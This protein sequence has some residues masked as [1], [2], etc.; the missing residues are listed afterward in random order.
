MSLFFGA[1][2]FISFLRGAI[3]TSLEP[4]GNNLRGLFYFWSSMTYVSS[5]SFRRGRL[6]SLIRIWSAIVGLLLAVLAFRWIAELAAWPI[7]EQWKS[8]GVWWPRVLDAPA[9]LVIA[10]GVLFCLY[11]HQRQQGSK[12]WLPAIPMLIAVV[13]LQHRTVWVAFAGGAVV[14]LLIQRGLQKQLLILASALILLGGIVIR[15]L[16]AATPPAREMPETSGFANPLTFQWRLDLWE[17]TIDQ[18]MVTP[19]D[20][21]LGVPFGVEREV[22]VWGGTVDVSPHNFY[23]RIAMRTGLLGLVS[24]LAIF[25]VLLLNI[26]RRLF[27]REANGQIANELALVVSVFTS[28]LIYYLAYS[29]KFEQGLLIGLGISIWGRIREPAGGATRDNR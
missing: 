18:Y 29:P 23:L 21:I 5:F 9:A 25:G 4:A 2:L 27:M 28:Q 24:F 1:L 26:A 11:M 6:V 12:W 15:L 14:W 10:M 13:I 8:V 20:I 22:Q 17:E 7:A 19:S 3:L 16:S